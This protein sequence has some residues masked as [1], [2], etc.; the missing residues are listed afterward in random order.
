MKKLGMITIA[1]LIFQQAVAQESSLSLKKII[2]DF[3]VSSNVET[4]TVAIEAVTV[5]FS[6]NGIPVSSSEKINFSFTPEEH[7]VPKMACY[8]VIVDGSQTINGNDF[9][10][11]S[12]TKK[13]GIFFGGLFQVSPGPKLSAVIYNPGEDVLI[14]KKIT[15]E[16][17]YI[18]IWH[19]HEFPPSL[20]NIKT[21]SFLPRHD[22]S[23]VTGSAPQ[24]HPSKLE[25][26][27]KFLYLY[28][29]QR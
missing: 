24:H 13:E 19:N 17:P 5:C 10:I 21:G 14:G 15:Y 22:V 3:T 20:F 6:E 1:L 12:R 23:P 4:A 7:F 8:H 9:Y 28:T 25:D 26:I 16:K 27:A 29:H 11:V 2:N 18:V